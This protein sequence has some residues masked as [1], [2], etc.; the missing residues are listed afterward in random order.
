M[1]VIF[2]GF[3]FRFSLNT[4]KENRGIGSLLLVLLP[5]YYFP[6]FSICTTMLSYIVYQKMDSTKHVV[7]LEDLTREILED[8]LQA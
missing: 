6:F 4:G 7:I 8:L 5:V 2:C 1:L 3:F